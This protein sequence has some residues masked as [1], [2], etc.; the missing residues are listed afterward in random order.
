MIKFRRKSFVLPALLPTLSALGN[1]AMVA[2]VPMMGIQM[3]QAS[4]AE[5]Q[6]KEIMEK[7]EEQNREITRAL[8]RIAKNASNN[9]E[10]A[11]QVTQVMSQ[12][13]QY[14][15]A[16]NVANLKALGKDL[17]TV[18][19]TPGTKKFIGTGL[20]SG[21]AGALVGYGVDK[22][23]Q[24]DIENITTSTSQNQKSYSVLTDVTKFGKNIYS[25]AKNN[26]NLGEVGAW[27]AFAAL[28]AIGYVAGDRKQIKDQIADTQNSSK[29]KNYAIPGVAFIKNGIKDSWGKLKTGYAE[30]KKHKRQ[31]I[32][33]GINNL[34]SYGNI[35][36]EKVLNFGKD[37]SKQGAKSGS[38]LTQ[39]M[40]KF[41]ED[42]PVTSLA[43]TIPVSATAVAG[44]YTLADNLT[45][46]G[47]EAVDKNAY[48][49]EKYKNQTI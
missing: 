24:K 14:S 29:Q 12:Q 20:A 21:A 18:L 28:P 2:S 25:K 33:G 38:V 16:I 13:R 5:K 4:D 46:K 48:A 15:S 44:T 47:L 37:L 27:S 31:S 41:I 3:K 34:V 7:T 11:K 8:N 49:Y 40:G 19:W 45:R 1:A 36:R 42:N 9:P 35:G 17:K 23:I 30:F 22:A 43:L 10:V 26:I 39:K 32:L 6:N